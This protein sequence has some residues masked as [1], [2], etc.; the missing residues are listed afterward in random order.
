MDKKA[1]KR[2]KVLN[3]KL[4][5]RQQQLAGA[6]QQPDEPDE[7]ERVQRE[8]EAIKEELHQLKGDTK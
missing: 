6:K 7:L 4:Q 2:I 8:I 5:N 3:D 1:K